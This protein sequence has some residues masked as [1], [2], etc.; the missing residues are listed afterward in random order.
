MLPKDAHAKIDNAVRSGKL[1]RPEI[2]EC[3]NKKP[4]KEYFDRW[5]RK[6]IELE[7][8]SVGIVAHHIDYEKPLEVI[9]L[10][11]KCHSKIHKIFRSENG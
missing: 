8:K 11:R 3:C 10:C 4:K 1:F 9:W 6:T 2:C 7:Y 5:L